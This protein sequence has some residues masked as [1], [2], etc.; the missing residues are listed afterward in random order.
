MKLDINQIVNRKKISTKIISHTGPHCYEKVL[1]PNAKIQYICTLP[2]CVHSLNI[3]SW[4]QGKE[5]LCKVCYQSFIVNEDH[6]LICENC[7][8]TS[9]VKVEGSSV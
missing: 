8:E 6:N 4:I 2:K 7:I 9:K 5:N 1:T 3:P